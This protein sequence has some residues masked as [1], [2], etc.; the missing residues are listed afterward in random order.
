[1]SASYYGRSIVKPHEWKPVIPLYF[2]IGGT[3]GAAAAAC[4]L[5]RIRG[6]H[7]L[8]KTYKRIALGGALVAPVLL[9]VDLGVPARFYNMF[10]VF[11]PTSP[12]SLGSWLLLAFGGALSLST[13]AE[14]AEL[15]WISIPLEFA[16]AALG[17]GV[18]TYT[19]VLIANT[20]TPV[21][22]EAYPTLPFVFVASGISGAGALAVLCAP[23][24]EAG[25]A[26]RA[27]LLGEAG[28]IASM[29]AMER[30]V[31][32]F[33]SEPYRQGKAGALQRAATALGA[34]AL[35]AGFFGK[36]AR[37]PTRVAGVLAIASGILERFA[38]VEAGTQSAKD[39]KY[40]VEG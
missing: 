37:W 16:A 9:T 31:G 11:K 12:M 36:K 29:R 4:V 17:P 23:N 18:T 39:P 24:E 5:A 35:A 30:Q 10:R 28:V 33:L 6:S 20:A 26:R 40:A 22:H 38:I 25:P 15:A 21:W 7:G 8:A 2:W 27:M 1:M 13:L 34:A 19:A 3:A 14:F 32:E